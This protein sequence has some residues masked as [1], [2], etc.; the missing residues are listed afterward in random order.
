MA[1]AGAVTASSAVAEA[2][3]LDDT[4]GITAVLDTHMVV[5]DTQGT[6]VRSTMAVQPEGQRATP[7]AMLARAEVLV[8]AV[9]AD[10]PAE[11]VLAA[12]VD[13]ASQPGQCSRVC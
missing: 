11:A 3:M 6:V 2:D 1:T 5:P 12:A 7:A 8:L 13:T 4:E 10:T 9:E